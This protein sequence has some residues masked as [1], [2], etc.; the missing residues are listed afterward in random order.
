MDVLIGWNADGA[1]LLFRSN[2]DR[3]GFDIYRMKPDGTDVTR[4][5][6]TR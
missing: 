2:R 1:H 3:R 6:N 4:V 5:T